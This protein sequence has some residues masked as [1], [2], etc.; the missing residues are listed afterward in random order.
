MENKQSGMKK[1]IL[2]GI[3]LLLVALAAFFKISSNNNATSA[4]ESFEGLETMPND[5]G[6][7]SQP[8]TDFTQSQA[9]QS[10]PVTQELT[11]EE[12]KE[13]MVAVI[14]AAKQDVA[15]AKEQLAAAKTAGD[16]TK[17]AEAQERLNTMRSVLKD[18]LDKNSDLGIEYPADLFKD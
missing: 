1:W 10:L 9:E 8:D 7:V 2:L 14:D 16:S 11:V 18:A 15:N 13:V 3:V 17:Q 6:E 12:R 4:L 5:E